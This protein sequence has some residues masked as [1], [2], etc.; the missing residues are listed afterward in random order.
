M[1]SPIPTPKP[2][3]SGPFLFPKAQSTVLPDPAKFFSPNLVST[4]LPTNSFFQNFVLN[5]GDQPEYIHPYLIKPSPSSSSLSLSYPSFFSTSAFI[6]QVFNA[7]LTIGKTSPE[8]SI[9]HAK[10]QVISSYDDL[11]VT[12]DI[13]SSNLRFF[14]V[15]GSPYLTM[16]V[17]QK[18]LIS[19]TTIHA[20]LSFSS[21]ESLTKYK[22]Q[23]NNG[24]TWLLYASSGIKL[25]NHGLSEITSDS[26][27][28]GMIR[29]AILPDSSNPNYEIVL[30]KHSSCYPVSGRASLSKPFCVEYEWEIKGWGDLLL[31]AHP[32]HL[33]LLANDDNGVTVLDDFKYRSIDGEL[34]GVVGDSWVLR[35]DPVSVTWNSTRGVK[36]DSHNEIVSSLLNDVKGLDSSSITT[37]SSY[38]YGKLIARAARLALIAEEVHFPDVIPAIRKFLKETI[39]PWMEGTF[40]GNGFLYDPKWGG[41]VTKQGSTDSGADFG[42]GIYNDHHYHLGYFLYGIAVLAK[43][44]PSWGRKYKPQAYSLMADF[45]NLG[46]RS[47]SN[48]TRL[49]CF[50]LYKLHSW[51]G[52]LTEFADGRNQESTSEAVN[53]YYSAALMGL[54]YGDSQLISLGSTLTAL[55]IH[56]SQM[57]WHL[58]KED[59]DGDHNLYGVDFTRENRIVGVLWANKRDSGL[60]FAPPAWKECRLGIQ[61]LPLLP[62]TEALFSNVKYV[63]DLVE[64]TLPA[65]NRDGVG[66]GWKGFV[67]ALEGIYD[68]ESA[69]EKIR[70]LKGFD[71][72]NSFTNLLWWIHSRGDEVEEGDGLFEDF[73]FAAV[74]MVTW[75]RSS[76]IG[77]G[78]G[79]GRVGDT[80]VCD[81]SIL[82][83]TL[84]FASQVE[85]KSVINIGDNA[86]AVQKFH[87]YSPATPPPSPSFSPP[88]PFTPPL[89][90][91]LPS[92]TDSPTLTP[93]ALPPPSPLLPLVMH[94][95]KQPGKSFLFPQ[96]QSTVLPDPSNFF[97]PNLVS[98]PLPTNSFFQNFV[99]KNGDQPEY[100]HPYLIKSS[101]S[102]LSISYP[103]RFFSSAFIYQVFN[104]DLTFGKTN[105]DPNG[106]HIISSYDDLSVT[107]EIPSSN[108]RFFLVRGSP[109]LTMAVTQRTQISLTTVHAILSFSSNDS[110]TKYTIQLNNGQTWLI[111]ASSSVKLSSHGLSEITSDDEF[112]GIIRVAVLPNSNSK[113]KTILDSFSSCYPISG[114]ASLSK[115]FSVEYKW[116]KKG[117][118]DLLLLAH[119]LHLQLLAND[120]S[121][122]TVLDDFKYKSI[123]GDLVGVVGDSWV[124]ETD[125]VYVTWQSTTGVKEESYNE[126]VSALMKDVESLN[127]SSIT[128]TSSYF[129]GKLIARAARLALIAEEVCFL[130]VIPTVRKFL[131]ETIEPWLEG[132]FN[133]NGFLYDAK[134]GGLVTKQGSTDSG[135]DFGFG[136]Y[137]DHH[138][139]LGYFLYGIAV[140]SKIDP[141]WGRKY[142]PQAYSLMQDFMNLG[143]RSNS[144]YTRLRCFDLYKLHSWAGGLTEFADGRNQESTSEAVNAY[145]SAALMGL[146]YGDVDLVATGS[147][148]T[149]LE[150]LATQ[151]WWHVKAGDNLYE[152]DFTRENRLVGVLWANK[153]DSGLWFAPAEWKECR[154]GI[155]VLPL[156]PITEALFSNVKYVKDLVDWTLPSLNREGVGEGW[157]G[158][159]YALEGIYD[160]DNALEK[161]RNLKGFDDG[162]SLT[163][164]L[165]WIHSRGDEVK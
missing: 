160:E 47:N 142:K 138:F 161:I 165:W 69:L 110:L 36:E 155:Q 34:V 112:T 53:A 135:G 32:L 43:I 21:N 72:G 68:K 52:G 18:T 162:N 51:A 99:L 122:I 123:D 109:Y 101:L 23:L 1:M 87:S 3:P 5:N 33:Q 67:Y 146:A 24:Q 98:S 84:T 97:S 164:L 13:P 89:T 90:S 152:E 44:D 83:L 127:S 78:N 118:G 105:P 62:I 103:S 86:A 125:P 60:W 129:Y 12:L 128:T 75:P 82:H 15:R 74:A 73:F 151:M 6:Y 140:L 28:M 141:A 31:L 46:R 14:L 45:M 158:F 30:D 113:Y 131:K 92:S 76:G 77:R 48:Y 104:A 22:F 38:F 159:V 102:S 20:I 117:W 106:K 91:S 49:R 70:K 136:I 35:T 7:D 10:Q 64:W 16:A 134:W 133:G 19:I 145:Y 56:A 55:E 124:L 9:N 71:D 4:P 148:L 116:E 114:K 39:E 26:E 37:A 85:N 41:L 120:N 54:A 2:R 143:R 94:P 108:L 126:I 79:E 42:F 11:S 57:W 144:N 157:K 111:Y 147:T 150:I 50:D 154:L 63:K 61:V 139:H 132:T 100:I 153:R 88:L 156:L 119:P 17:T 137:N 95:K 149:A 25:S 66:E 130:D 65:L 8:D 29:I 58:K 40:N 107:L 163:N 80:G 96:V 27:F 59:D 115:P 93:P 81:L 121:D